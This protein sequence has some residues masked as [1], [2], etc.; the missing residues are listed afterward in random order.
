[1]FNF[2]FERNGVEMGLRFYWFVFEYVVELWVKSVV[3]ILV[4][5]CC[6]N[7]IIYLIGLR[8]FSS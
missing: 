8:Y 7:F 6:R 4:I 1:M 2:D 3:L 5:M